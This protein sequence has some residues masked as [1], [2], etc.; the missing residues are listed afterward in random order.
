MATPDRRPF[1]LLMR[2]VLVPFLAYCLVALSVLLPVARAKAIEAAGLDRTLAVLCLAGA[3]N[4]GHSQEN[5]P[6]ESHHQLDCCTLAARLILDQPVLLVVAEI[7]APEPV[8]VDLPVWEAQPQG[9]APPAITAMPRQPQ[10]PPA[11]R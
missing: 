8:L 6:A 9:R 2:T 5:V 3:I 7:P 10:A 11:V 1:R 4:P